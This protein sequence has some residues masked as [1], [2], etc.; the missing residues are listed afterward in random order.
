MLEHVSR[1]PL[2]AFSLQSYAD[3]DLRHHHPNAS[4]PEM[5]SLLVIAQKA[6][7]HVAEEVE[8][9]RAHLEL[10]ELD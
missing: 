10:V 9:G 8:F 4:H 3:L 2:A 1:C 5:R 7:Y 6:Q